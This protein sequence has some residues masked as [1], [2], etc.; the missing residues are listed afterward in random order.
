MNM[1]DS[2]NECHEAPNSCS[3]QDHQ[4]KTNKTINSC[5]TFKVMDVLQFNFFGSIF[6]NKE[7]RGALMTTITT[8]STLTCPIKIDTRCH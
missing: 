7:G 2:C 8:T 3:S 6:K 5:P 4:Q 1:I